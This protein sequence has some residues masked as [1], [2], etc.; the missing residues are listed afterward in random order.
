MWGGGK[1]GVATYRLCMHTTFHT[2]ALSGLRRVY[3]S[4]HFPH[5]DLGVLRISQR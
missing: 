5:V 3:V 2:D 1:K 4:L